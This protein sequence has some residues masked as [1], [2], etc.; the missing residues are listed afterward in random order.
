VITLAHYLTLSGILFS[1]GLMGVITR[2]NALVLLMASIALLISGS[3][4]LA[5]DSW[6]R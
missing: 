3:G 1:I 6:R 4:P 2:R 5:V